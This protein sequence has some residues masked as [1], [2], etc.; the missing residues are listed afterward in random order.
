ME[1]G[2]FVLD[3]QSLQHAFSAGCRNGMQAYTFD[4]NS[5]TR[6]FFCA[7]LGPAGKPLQISNKALVVADDFDMVNQVARDPS[8]IGY[9]SAAAA[10]PERVQFLGLQTTDGVVHF[11]PRDTLR[12]R[13]IREEKPTW[14]LIRTLYAHYGGKAW[15]ADGTGIVNV[16]LAPGAPGTKALQAGPLYQA[17]YYLP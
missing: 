13:C 8:A 6:R 10:D 7:R 11:Y 2:D 9:C 12:C 5:G 14:P 3:K 1:N 15:K 16:M 17:S 4:N